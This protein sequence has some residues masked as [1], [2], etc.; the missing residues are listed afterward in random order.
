MLLFF[1]LLVSKEK[2]NEKNKEQEPDGYG[3]C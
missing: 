3:Y 2:P 1:A